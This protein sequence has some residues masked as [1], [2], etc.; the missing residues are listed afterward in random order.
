MSVL[1]IGC[2]GAYCKTCKAFQGGNCRG[3]KLG[4]ENGE[5]NLDKSKC[6]IKLCCFK[7]NKLQTCADCKEFNS[8]TVIQHWYMK[9]GSKYQR[10]KKSSEYIRVKGYKNFLKIADGWKDASG[11]LPTCHSSGAP[12][13][14]PA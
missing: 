1:G 9:T 10:Y 12:T 13:A 7:E 6:K 5:R 14:A 4:Y 11:K 8:C 2:C 3:C